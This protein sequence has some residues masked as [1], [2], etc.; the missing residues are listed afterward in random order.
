M[1]LAA[2]IH[3]KDEISKGQFDNA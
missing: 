2:V 3:L 1:V